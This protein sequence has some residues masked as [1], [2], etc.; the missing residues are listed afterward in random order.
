MSALLGYESYHVYQE[1]RCSHDL[2]L[3]E[4]K[5]V[6][7]ERD[8]PFGVE[9]KSDWPSGCYHASKVWYNKA[10]VV[11]KSNTRCGRDKVKRCFCKRESLVSL[12]VILLI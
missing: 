11:D 8:V 5:K 9:T 12:V 10:N 7:K 1:G 4:C 2:S 3:Q 6:A